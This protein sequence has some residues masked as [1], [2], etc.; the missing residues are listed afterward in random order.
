[1]KKVRF[2]IPA[3]VLDLSDDHKLE[4]LKSLGEQMGIA[5]VPN[6]HTTHDH[7]RTMWTPDEV[8]IIAELEDWFYGNLS[9]YTANVYYDVIHALE[10][11]EEGEPLVEVVKAIGADAADYLEKAN[12]TFSLG[13]IIRINREGREKLWKYV[14]DGGTYSRAELERLH[15]FINVRTPNL[16]PLL[17]A[18]AVRGVFL[19]KIKAI[20]DKNSL[21]LLGV[22]LSQLPVRIEQVSKTSTP[23]ALR[24]VGGLMKEIEVPPLTDAEVHAIRYAEQH[25]AQ[26][27]TRDSD[28]LKWRIQRAVTE[29]RR[30]RESSQEL[31][32]RLL[33]QYGEANRDW[34]RIALTE[35]TDVMANGY[36][37]SLPVGSRVYGQ[38]AASACPH[39]KRLIIGKVY[40][41][42]DGPLDPLQN[43]WV[44]KTNVGRRVREY[45]PTIPLHP[46]CRCRWVVLSDFQDVDDDG[47][48]FI[49]PLEELIEDYKR[50]GLAHPEYTMDTGAPKEG[51]T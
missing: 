46:H 10:L 2:K 27:V 25:A 26:Y 1:M 49:K 42:S 50:R 13:E 8:P 16:G 3:E 11:P 23:L 18:Y 5:V 34:R 21:E 47:N 6:K 19:G 7:E 22:L 44:G 45:V 32:Q 37:A 28:A 14:A 36:L 41:L 12:G 31:R 33:D 29:A 4:L 51:G 9:G 17:E 48:I 39:C 15:A 40:T 35:L 30:N 43:V 38:G 24:S 20:A